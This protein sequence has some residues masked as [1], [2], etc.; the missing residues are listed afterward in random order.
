M[1]YSVELVKA[2][3]SQ[4]ERYLDEAARGL[5]FG[6]EF[7]SLSQLD[8]DVCVMMEEEERVTRCL[9]VC[10]DMINESLVLENFVAVLGAGGDLESSKE[11]YR[12]DFRKQLWGDGGWKE[13]V[14]R[15]IILIRERRRI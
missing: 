10:L 12:V 3:A 4:L 7:N 6:C 14:I 8:H 2:Y 11:F 9:S 15:E 5:C 1:E 13:D